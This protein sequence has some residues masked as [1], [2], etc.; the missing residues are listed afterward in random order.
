MHLA[1]S[2]DQVDAIILFKDWRA[3]GRVTRYTRYI[4]T[5]QDFQQLIF[6]S[7][8]IGRRGNCASDAASEGVRERESRVGAR[9]RAPLDGSRSPASLGFIILNIEHS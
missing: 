3:K 4:A 9:P 6:V 5:A 1:D 7:W 8:T 2:E